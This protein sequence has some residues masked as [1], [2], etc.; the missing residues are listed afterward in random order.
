MDI[1]IVLRQMFILFSLMSVGFTLRKLK[2]LDQNSDKLL[3][4]L[5]LSVVLPAA[6]LLGVTGASGGR[7]NLYLA[8]V[9]GISL[10]AFVI[11]GV[12]AWTVSRLMG[13][14]ERTDKG[15]LASIGMFGNLVYMGFPLI[16]G[17]FGAE[18]M[19]Y[20]VLFNFISNI[21]A[22]SLG[23]RLLTGA[24]GSLSLKQLVNP[25]MCTS[26]FA[27]L[28]FM[29]NVRIPPLIEAPLSHLG[30]MLTP[31]GMI[32]IGSILGGMEVKEIFFGWRVY[33]SIGMK[34][35]IAPVAVF[36]VLSRFVADPVLLGILVVLS[37]MPTAPRTIMLCI[38]H[39]GNYKMI[40]QGIFI[41]TVLSILT[42][43]LV[44][45]VLGI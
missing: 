7:G 24:Q 6:I 31:L 13:A 18:N 15:A 34:L 1:T 36:L 30:N 45:H 33:V 16:L 10:L 22:F 41:A 17:L 26:V 14:K 11:T 42:I 27:I 2:I 21:F 4:H 9:L 12:L 32:L 37:A 8:Y 38:R 29:L 39:G 35:L 44:I 28:L 5:V 43:P 3:T 25:L 19:F 40:S 23:I 20:A